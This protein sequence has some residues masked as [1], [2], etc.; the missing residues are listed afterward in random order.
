MGE[1]ALLPDLDCSGA[2]KECVVLIVFGN[3]QSQR[4]CCVAAGA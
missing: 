4:E 3:A 1:N 2:P